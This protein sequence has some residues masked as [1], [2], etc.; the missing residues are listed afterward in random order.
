MTQVAL[1]SVCM[2]AVL[3]LVVLAG[4]PFLVYFAYHRLRHK[5]RLAEVAAR[6][7]L[8]RGGSRYLAYSAG[9]ASLGV[10]ALVLW[11]PSLD[12]FVR[13]GSPQRAFL[14]LGL[15]PLSLAMALVYGIVTTGFVEE[16][17][18]RGLVAGSLSRRVSLPWANVGQAV[19]F[20]APHLLV[21]KVMPELWMILPL[22]FVSGLVLG[23]IR[24]KSG[25]IVGPWLV[26]ASVNAATCLSVAIRT[27]T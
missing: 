3:N 6:A 7:G 13:Q 18:F 16:F 10:G 8:R 5:R 23:W 27:A 2:S 14:G 9:L 22:V 26:H 15:S 11:P 24:I 17:L 4:I 12:L 19:V 20:L 25:S 1:A 21:L